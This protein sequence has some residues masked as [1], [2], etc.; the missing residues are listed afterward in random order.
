MAKKKKIDKQ[1]LTF[2][3]QFTEMVVLMGFD[4]TGEILKRVKAGERP[5]ELQPLINFF[6]KR[7]QKLPPSKRAAHTRKARR[8]AAEVR[9]MKER[10]EL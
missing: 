7:H 1:W 9:A 4:E 10:G 2:L 8:F 5:A 6:V 3:E